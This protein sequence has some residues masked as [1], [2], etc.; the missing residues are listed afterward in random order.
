MGALIRSLL[1]FTYTTLFGSYATFLYMR[2]GSL[3][4]VI[5]VHAF[6][7]WMGFPRFWGRVSAAETVIGPDLGE[8]KRGEDAK[9]SNGQLSVVWTIAYYVLLVVGA[10]GWHKLLW[11]LT[12]SESALSKF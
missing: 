11:Q 5:L 1:Q 9:P 6:C 3:L 10:V 8:A 12:E 7:N 4:G 2:T